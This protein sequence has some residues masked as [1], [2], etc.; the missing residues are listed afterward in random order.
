[1][2]WDFGIIDGIRVLHTPDWLMQLTAPSCRRAVRPRQARHAQMLL[3][4]A[5]NAKISHGGY[6]KIL[7]TRCLTQGMLCIR[8]LPMVNILRQGSRCPSTLS[9]CLIDT[10][11]PNL[12][13]A[14]LWY[15]RFYCNVSKPLPYCAQD[16]LGSGNIRS[17]VAENTTEVLSVWLAKR[18][19]GQPRQNSAYYAHRKTIT[20]TE[21]QRLSYLRALC[22]SF[23]PSL[24]PH[25]L[26]LTWKLHGSFNRQADG[27][28][29]RPAGTLD[30]SAVLR[31]ASV[32]VALRRMYL[33]I[34]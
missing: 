10:S 32:Q 30:G 31:C 12:Y 16:S 24:S 34:T 14:S 18:Y 15:G 1:M 26:R 5:T 6:G 21:L 33:S 17:T 4:I 9:W 29:A 2:T 8:R 7:P 23:S 28:L 25:S 27:G 11:L 19:G 3:D 20:G 13:R 22:F